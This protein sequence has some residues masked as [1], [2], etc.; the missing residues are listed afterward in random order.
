M[1]CYKNQLSRELV[2][3]YTTVKPRKPPRSAYHFGGHHTT[4]KRSRASKETISP[5]PLHNCI[6][7]FLVYILGKKD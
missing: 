1:G 2:I 6:D 5:P 4:F 7:I 3:G